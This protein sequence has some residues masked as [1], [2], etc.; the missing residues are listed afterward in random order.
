MVV[1]LGGCRPDESLTMVKAY[2]FEMLNVP[3]IVGTLLHH[4]ELIRAMF[5]RTFTTRY[6]ASAL[7]LIWA[8][9]QPISLMIVYTIVFAYFL[10]VRFANSDN[11]LIF[12]LYLLC[13]QL[14]W[15]AFYESTMQA[16]GLIRSNT[17]LVKRV[18]FP[19]EILPITAAMKDRK[20]T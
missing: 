16:T 4:H 14:A 1:E 17:N 11:P 10:N 6:R 3:A 18:V 20:S 19:L 13:G 12:P 2:L 9:V 15:G 7:G 5:W 8:L